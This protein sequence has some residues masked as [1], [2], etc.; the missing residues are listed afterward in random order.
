MIGNSVTE[1]NFIITYRESL[2]LKVYFFTPKE[3][4]YKLL[5]LCSVDPPDPPDLLGHGF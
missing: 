1:F 5:T 2:V 4:L 3:L